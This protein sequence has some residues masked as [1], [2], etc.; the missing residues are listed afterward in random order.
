MKI[1]RKSLSSTLAL[2]AIAALLAGCASSGYEKGEKTASHLESTASEIELG[3]AQVQTTLDTLNDLVQK[4]SEDLRPQYKAFAKD[5]S[6]VVATAKRVNAK[7]EKLA[8]AS[9]AY[10]DQWDEQ[11]ATIANADIRARS[12]ARKAKVLASLAQVQAQYQETKANFS[13]FLSDLQDLDK[14]LSL[15]LTPAGVDSLK[16]VVAQANK[17]GAELAKSLDS[18]TTGFR[19]LGAKLSPLLPKPAN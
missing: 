8:A 14:A 16:S 7:T 6:K 12:E 3:K 13:P 19:D 4:P 17:H 9:Q 15:D 10:A 11:S 2:A 1:N 5:V 18:L